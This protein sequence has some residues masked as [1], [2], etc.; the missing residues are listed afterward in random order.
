MAN[1]QAFHMKTIF[2][3]PPSQGAPMLNLGST[4]LT[5]ARLA[6]ELKSARMIA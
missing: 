5:Q 4:A 2:N 3:L 6:E 1:Q